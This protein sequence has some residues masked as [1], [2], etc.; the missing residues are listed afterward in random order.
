MELKD[1]RERIDTI[2]GELV[3]LFAERMDIAAKVADYKKANNLPIYVPARER[4]ILNR[5]WSWS[6]LRS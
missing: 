2:D 6:D 1:L 5:A 3:G 4:E